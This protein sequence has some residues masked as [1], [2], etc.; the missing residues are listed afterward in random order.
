LDF[1]FFHIVFIEWGKYA[2]CLGVP[3]NHFAGNWD[4]G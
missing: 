3:S 1:P 2:F 4:S